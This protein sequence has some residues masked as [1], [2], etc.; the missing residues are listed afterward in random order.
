MKK[1]LLFFCVGLIAFSCSNNKKMNPKKAEES[2]KTYIKDKI[3]EANTYEAIAFGKLDS[4]RLEETQVYKKMSEERIRLNNSVNSLKERMYSMEQSGVQQAD[5]LYMELK[6]KLDEEEKQL[7]KVE[8]KME[9]YEKRSKEYVYSLNHKY[10]ARK[11]HRDAIMIY[12][13]VFYI[14]KNN[15]II[16]DITVCKY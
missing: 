1:Y 2:I 8:G 12:D 3:A 16:E 6:E 13:E 7:K 5:R 9:E 11:K 4:I 10:K 14:D 15:N